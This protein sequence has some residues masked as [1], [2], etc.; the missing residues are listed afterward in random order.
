L[1]GIFVT[2][3]GGTFV[4]IATVDRG[5]ITPFRRRTRVRRTGVTVVARD[6]SIY[7]F[8]VGTRIFR[9]EIVVAAIDWAVRTTT[10]KQVP[11]KN[12]IGGALV[13]IVTTDRERSTV[14]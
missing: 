14:R 10:T 4:I 7:A 12:G 1:T 9:T 11:P 13:V 3:V 2:R 8:S 6:I 5:I